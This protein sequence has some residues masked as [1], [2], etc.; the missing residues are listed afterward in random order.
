VQECINARMLQG[1]AFDVSTVLWTGIHGA[2][3][4]LTTQQNFPFGSRQRYATEV[5]ATLLAGRS[6]TRDRADIALRA[7]S[8]QAVQVTGRINTGSGTHTP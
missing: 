3:T 1:D 2:A 6:K 4:I 7:D 5:V 8:N